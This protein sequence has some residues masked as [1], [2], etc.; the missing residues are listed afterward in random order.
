MFQ[1]SLSLNHTVHN[2]DQPFPGPKTVILLAY[3]VYILAYV[4]TI[5]HQK[6]TFCFKPIPFL[7]TL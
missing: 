2:S 7:F 6:L 4:D 1:Y 5:C 3:V